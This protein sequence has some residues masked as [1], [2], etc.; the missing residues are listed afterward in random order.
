MTWLATRPDAPRVPNG[1]AMA[2]TLAGVGL[3][4]ALAEA[5]TELAGLGPRPGAFDGPLLGAVT[6]LV[7]L[8]AAVHT[9]RVRDDPRR[10]RLPT[11]PEVTAGSGR[12]VASA[13]AV[14]TPGT[15]P[16]ANVRAV[17][18]EGVS[19]PIQVVDIDWR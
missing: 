16:V 11:W 19:E 17:T 7:M 1:L 13:A 10:M 8:L 18:L 12:M 14:S 4:I 3:V 2:A 15:H 6:P 5:T 9:V